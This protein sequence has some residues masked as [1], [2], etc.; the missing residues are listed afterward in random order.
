MSTRLN[1]TIDV[2]DAT[3]LPITLVQHED[4]GRV[5]DITVTG[6][7]DPFDLTGKTVHFVAVKPDGKLV[8]NQT[9]ITDPTNGKCEYSVTAQT[10]AVHGDMQAHLQIRDDGDVLLSRSLEITIEKSIEPPTVPIESTDETNATRDA[11]ALAFNVL[12]GLQSALEGSEGLIDTVNEAVSLANAAVGAANNAVGAANDAIDRADTAADYA[13]N[14]G[15]AAASAANNANYAAT[16]A[17][18]AAD[19]L[20]WR[21]NYA[22]PTLVGGITYPEGIGYMKFLRRLDERWLRTRINFTSFPDGSPG[23]WTHVLTIPTGSRSAAISD[24]NRWV[25]WGPLRE[26]GCASRMDSTGKVEVVTPEG[27]EGV[28]LDMMWIVNK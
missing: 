24:N 15:D 5:L 8:I 21:D 3:T 10:V 14:T 1:V 17:R 23:I 28:Y 4:E 13:E 25:A 12:A 7:G 22:P 19:D 9:V 27:L 11:I 16:E 26:S 20:Y 6:H 2:W 18:A